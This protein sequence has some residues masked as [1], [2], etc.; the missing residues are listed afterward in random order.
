MFI[1]IRKAPVFFKDENTA[2]LSLT[3][4]YGSE[5]LTASLVRQNDSVYV[6]R[7]LQGSTLK[8]PKNGRWQKIPKVIELKRR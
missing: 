3:N 6:L 7:Q 2:E 4:D 8:V 1:V 5:D